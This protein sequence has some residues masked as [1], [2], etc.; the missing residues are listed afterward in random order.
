[1]LFT[2]NIV[3]KQLKCHVAKIFH[4]KGQ[5]VDMKHAICKLSTSYTVEGVSNH[6]QLL[7]ESESK[8][9]PHSLRDDER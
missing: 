3:S 8:N 1:V 4:P 6:R 5:P 2:I 7:P 9:L